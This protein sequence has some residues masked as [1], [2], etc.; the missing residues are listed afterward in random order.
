MDESHR[1]FLSYRRDDA[2]ADTDL[3]Y[4]ELAAYFGEDRVFYDIEKIGYGDD[5]HEAI[6]ARIADCT[7][8]VA[9]IGASWA[10]LEKDGVRRLDDPDDYVR[11]EIATALRQGKRVIPVLLEG[12]PMPAAKRLP[13]EI[14]RIARLNAVEIDARHLRRD[15]DVLIGAIERKRLAHKLA[16]VLATLRLRRLAWWVVPGVAIAMSFAAWTALFDF[17]TLDTR[18]ASYTMALGAPFRHRPADPRVELVAIDAES[19]QR[20]GRPFDRSWRRE[21]AQLIDRLAAGGARVIAFDLHLAEPGPA[22]AALVIAVRGATAAGTTVV[23]GTLDGRPPP[24]RGLAEAGARFALLCAGTR[25]GL[26]SV[27]PLAVHNRRAPAALSLVAAFPDAVLEEVDPVA[28]VL[29]L[30]TGEG[31]K[32]VGYSVEETLDAIPKACPALAKGDVVA[33]LIVDFRPMAAH[34]P[35]RHRYADLL[36][37]DAAG[38]AA[39]RDRIVLVGS[40]APADRI[41]VLRGLATEDRP[42]YVVH[43]DALNTL[44]LATRIRSL[45]T[46]AQFLIMLAMGAAG[47][48]ARL[49]RPLR[50]PLLRRTYLTAIPLAYVAVALVAYTAHDILLNPAYHLGAFFIAYATFCRIAR[51]R[52]LLETRTRPGRIADAA[53]G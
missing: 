35:H 45:G 23:F 25:L 51:R 52:Q 21:H 31:L 5:F 16:D 33:Q 28:G 2:P 11:L 7:V 30:R 29:L 41:P 8:L 50:S 27:V 10:T 18:I 32:R 15:V 9:L 4:R 14:A 48:G 53:E 24:I 43:A 44:L 40:E 17:L 49:L 37:L 6:D 20:V 26:A 12:T 3:V 38:A 39:F 34:A 42:G 46:S 36:Q 47:V 22:D 13:P 19:E 1:I